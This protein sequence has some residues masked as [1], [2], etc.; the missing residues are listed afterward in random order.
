MMTSRRDG[1]QIDLAGIVTLW[2]IFQRMI[3]PSRRKP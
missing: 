2:L 1:D 3:L